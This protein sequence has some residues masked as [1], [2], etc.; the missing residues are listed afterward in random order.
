M[1][2]ARITLSRA[3]GWRMPDNTVKVDRTTKWGNPF[4]IPKGHPWKDAA[5]SIL[6]FSFWID[7]IE[8]WDDK[9]SPPSR[10]EIQLVLRGKNLA[11]W[12]KP[13]QPCHADVLLELATPGPWLYDDRGGNPDAYRI[14]S[15]GHVM[16]WMDHYHQ[17]NHSDN[18][19]LAAAA[20]DLA[21]QLIATM[22]AQAR[23][24]EAARGIMLTAFRQTDIGENHAA[25]LMGVSDRKAFF[26]IR[27]AAR[28]VLAE[29]ETDK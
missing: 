27:D 25:G 6:Q 1:N 21:A 18:A 9:P 5:W 20:P 8:H 13:G 29:L 3:K 2:P 7:R 26:D 15:D 10:D 22:E 16:A 11:C 19:Q 14:I 4:P 12:C 28:A 17:G 23:L 24:V